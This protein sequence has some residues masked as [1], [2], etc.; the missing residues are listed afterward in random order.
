MSSQ[1]RTRPG[2]PDL[3]DQCAATVRGHGQ[4]DSVATVRAERANI[5]AA[6]GWT[7]AHDQPLGVRIATGFGWTWVVLGDGVSGAERLRGALAAAEPVPPQ[8]QAP[9]SS[10]GQLAGGICRNLERAQADLERALQIAEELDDDHLRAD[11]Q[12]HGAFLSIQLG[13]PA[14][15]VSLASTSVAVSRTLGLSWDVA[16]ALL[17]RAYGSIMVGDTSSAS[18][19][20]HEAIR[21]L[22]PI[23][24][25]WGLV[26]AEAM[27]GAIAQAE[28]RFQDASQH[29]TR[30]SATSELLGFV[31]QAALHLASLG[32]VQQREGNTQ[33]AIPTLNRAIL[34]ATNSGD[35]RLAATARLHLARLM[36]ATGDTDAARSLLEQNDRWYRS[37]GGG[38]GALLTQCLLAAV[39]AQTAR[40]GM[41]SRAPEILDQARRAGDPE[42]Q[43]YATDA[44]ARL[45]SERGDLT[46]AEQLLRAADDLAVAAAHVV[47][48]SDRVDADY[49]PNAP[50]RHHKVDHPSGRENAPPRIIV[51]GPRRPSRWS[52]RAA[53]GRRARLPQPP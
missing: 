33:A 43:V 21:L 39:N 13:R 4:A 22:T 14:D 40:Y 20:A 17:L 29:L 50:G 48:G 51:E 42:V 36:R 34:A 26:H 9:A 46:K 8:A 16:A 5:D 6:L 24:D 7:A 44:L 41:P 23:G 1:P 30:A 19:D 38:D 27:L 52:H 2:T 25:S 28:H 35:L 11:A 49:V 12:R 53:P 45:A 37:A 47:D 32:R 31:G 15:V 3:A 10:H 18:R